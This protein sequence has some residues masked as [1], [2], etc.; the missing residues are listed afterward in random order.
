MSKDTI[1]NKNFIQFKEFQPLICTNA[2]LSYGTT[3]HIDMNGNLHDNIG[4]LGR[5]SLWVNADYWSV[6]VNKKQIV[7]SEN[8]NRDNIRTLRE[9]II[10][11][12]FSGIKDDAANESLL[13]SYDDLK[14]T[15]Y[16]PED[17]IYDL[18]TF[19]LPNGTIY[20]Y[21]DSFYKSRQI[22]K[23]RYSSWKQVAVDRLPQN[24]L[25]NL[26]SI[27]NQYKIKG[28]QVYVRFGL[29]GNIKKYVSDTKIQPNF[30]IET[31][32]EI[33]PYYGFRL[34]ENRRL[35]EKYL[36]KKYSLEELGI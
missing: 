9:F 20:Y 34:N 28:G 6:N 12:T 23:K 30:Q 25:N 2:E 8:I 27:I 10:G 26:N 35:N 36:S 4:L 24:Y 3:M 7:D 15:V 14:I 1:I 16:K 33:F 31:D 13:I 17:D 29:T 19:Y 21:S 5:A 32:S 18:I 11:K 22:D